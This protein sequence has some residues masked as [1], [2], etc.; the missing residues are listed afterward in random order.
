M[1]DL[2]TFLSV[3]LVFS[4]YGACWHPWALV[5]MVERMKQVNRVQTTRLV[6]TAEWGAGR[7]LLK[8]ALT[9]AIGGMFVWLLAQRLDDFNLNDV[10]A[11]LALVPYWN[12]VGA[13]VATICAFWAVG[14]Y[15]AVLHRH[16]ETGVD[17]A[18][19]R[20]AGICAIAVSQTLGLGVVT[21]AILRWRML[22]DQSLGMATRI[23]VGVA[24][25]FLAGWA[26]VT[27][28]VLA[29]LPDAP[30]QEVASLVL[31]AAVAVTVLA[32]IAP[33]A[34]FRWPN[35]FTM[36]QLVWF[37]ALDTMAAAVG[38][39]IMIPADAGLAFATLLPAFLIAYGAGLMSGSPGGIGAFEV[40]LLAL[41][42]DLANDHLMAGIV[43]WRLVY[44]VLPALI[45]AFFA[46]IGPA[47]ARHEPQ[48]PLHLPAVLP[49]A[50]IGIYAQG[51]HGLIGDKATWMVGRRAHVMVGMF[52]PLAKPA[53]Q[54]LRN[55][56]AS[57]ARWPAIYKS[58]ARTAVT[59]RR[60]RW[61]SLRCA[62]EAVLHPS[63]YDLKHPRRA[64][65]RRKLR[66]AAAAGVRV[67]LAE[68][69]MDWPAM[70]AVAAAWTAD[71]GGERGFSM[72]R[73]GRDYVAGQ[74]VYLAWQK[75]ALVAF[76]TLHET[77][78]EWTLDLMRHGDKIADGT[79]HL[80]VS[81]AIEDAKALGVARLSLAAVPQSA[82][83]Q[84]P[85]PLARFVTV[86]HGL[87]QFKDTFA[88]KWEGRYLSAPHLPALI[89]AACSIGLAIAHPPKRGRFAP[90]MR[91]VFLLINYRF[92]PI[93]VPWQRDV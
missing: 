90:K 70:D 14:Q 58:K 45:G 50:E 27:A 39:Y 69:S 2:P 9:L 43:A 26:V 17:S 21:G 71:H 77:C 53:L 44:F 79:M 23:T 35:G 63:R 11:G 37:C 36:V 13:L 81:R 54:I 7:I 8:I 48:V 62:S 3:N 65:L 66:R 10:R 6:L 75:D 64:G 5:N 49:C 56:A 88:P 55:A 80:L 33:K 34:Q 84:L 42:P 24:L 74:R 92:D 89:L 16:F 47:R 78:G 68:T 41:L 18:R 91:R 82:F 30:Y 15:D 72:G 4:R 67:C 85:K 12:W 40:T 32:L 60:N 73:Y 52:D 76:I 31:G 87:R 22:P 51:A 61:V 20:R 38:L 19:A 25:S 46:M 28:I 29:L 83:W 59:A 1:K 93:R 57:E 86:G